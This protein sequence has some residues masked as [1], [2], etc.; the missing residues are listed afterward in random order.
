MHRCEAEMEYPDSLLRGSLFVF[1]VL[2]LDGERG[3]EFD[4][5]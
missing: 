2:A 3:L 5:Q 4:M 1:Y